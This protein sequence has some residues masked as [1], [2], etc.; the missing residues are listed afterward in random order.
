MELREGDFEA[1]F[2]APFVVYGETTPYVSPMKSDLRR[3]YT[4]GDNPLFPTS[5]NF[6]LFTAHRDGKILGRIGANFGAGMTGG[7]A[8]VWDPEGTARGLMNMETL[9][10][11]P[12]TVPHPARG[13]Q[14]LEMLQGLSARPR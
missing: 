11:G 14:S 4:V 5:D 7:M 1:F 13:E 12:V 9:V 8:Y 2:E 10:T 3:F 6:A